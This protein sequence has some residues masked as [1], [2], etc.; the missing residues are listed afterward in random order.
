[1]STRENTVLQKTLGRILGCALLAYGSTAL[2]FTLI[3]VP[4]E[5]K[6]STDITN[7][8]TLDAQVQPIAGTI[9]SQ[10]FGLRRAGSSQKTTQL[11]GLMLAANDRSG[12]RSDVDYLAAAA[13]DPSGAWGVNSGGGG[14]TQSLWISTM[15]DSL[16][17]TFSRTAFYG[18]TQNVLVGYD[19]TRSDRYVLGISGG[20]EASNYVTKFNSGNEKTGGYNV[21]PYFAWL[22]S[23]AWS[24]DLIGGYGKFN[25]DQSRAALVAVPVDSNFSSKRAFASTNLT[26]ISTSG[27]W[28]LTS[29]LGYLWSKRDQDGYT[30]SD[31]ITT[32]AG[33]KQTS[34]QWNLLEEVAYGRGNSETF[35]G[36]RYEDIRNYQKIELTSGLGEQPANDPT[37]FLLTAGW[38]YFGRGLTASFVFSGRVAQEQVK[39]HGFS[40]VLRADI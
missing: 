1:V 19:V 20:Y 30:E 26:N 27:N 38:R 23:D 4:E 15:I 28:K 18:A 17:N 12:S 34:K 6:P 14:N 22:M 25:T 8:F 9:R 7:S 24:L 11:G 10:I 40:M 16:E 3:T 31:G 2:A 29:S 35:V 37:S 5:L 13:N 32:V 33:T 21:N 39:E 36:A